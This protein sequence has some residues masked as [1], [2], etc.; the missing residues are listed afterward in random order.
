[1]GRRDVK[2]PLDT[3]Q[4]IVKIL[5][6]TGGLAGALCLFTVT[7]ITFYEVVARYIFDSPTTWSLDY[8]IYL[9]MWAT[10]IGAAYTL[11]WHGHINVEVLVD[12]FPKKSQRQ[13]KIFVYGL[14]LVFCV[15]L[16]WTGLISCLDA[17]RYKEVTLSYTRTPLYVPM[18]AIVAGGI[19]MILEIIRQLIE[20]FQISGDEK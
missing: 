15:I 3:F 13:L 6:I 14:A 20:L 9:V 7:L 11:M 10:F 4:K 12:K 18:F 5:V 17:Y 8:S 16:T 2:K 1:M 19:L